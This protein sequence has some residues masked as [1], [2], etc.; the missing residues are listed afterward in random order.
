[1][2]NRSGQDKKVPN[3]MTK[4]D[5]LIDIKNRASAIGDAAGGNQN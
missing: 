2:A 3:E 1:M 4:A 5:T